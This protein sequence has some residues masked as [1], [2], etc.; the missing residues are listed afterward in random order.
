VSKLFSNLKLLSF[1][2]A[3]SLSGVLTGCGGGGTA[4]TQPGTVPIGA[5]TQF[6]VDPAV[7]PLLETGDGEIQAT[8]LAPDSSWLTIETNGTGYGYARNGSFTLFPPSA[9]QNGTDIQTY[10]AGGSHVWATYESTQGNPNSATGTA[11]LPIG[12]SSAVQVAGYALLNV[13]AV[14]PD[15]TS[16]IAAAV[17]Q[18]GT[19]TGGVATITASGTVSPVSIPS[20]YGG[21][22][23]SA[24]SNGG[25][26]VGSSRADN[27]A[28]ILISP[29]GQVVVL[30]GTNAHPWAVDDAGNSVGEAGGQAAR[31]S[32]SGTLTTLGRFDPTS[33]R[34]AAEGIT[35]TGLAVGIAKI[36]GIDKAI[37]WTTA[38]VPVDLTAHFTPSAGITAL[39]EAVAIQPSGKIEVFAETGSGIALIGIEPSTSHG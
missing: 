29:Q 35:D 23:P 5:S 25:W 11:I 24:R 12:G 31:W 37:L 9:I 27:N 15:G 38:G 1:T 3:V 21:F 14:S 26:T 39:D 13:G 20:Q 10:G 16:A 36:G 32:A 17:D 7:S 28:G 22:V 19:Q 2:T 8:G 6:V 4:A 18:T 34:E 30:Q 33:T